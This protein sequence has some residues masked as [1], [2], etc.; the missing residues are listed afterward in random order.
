VDCV[1][2]FAACLGGFAPV[3]YLVEWFAA[4]LGKLLGIGIAEPFEVVITPPFK[5]QWSATCT[6]F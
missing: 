6:M 3:P 4:A 5:R 1:V 2:K